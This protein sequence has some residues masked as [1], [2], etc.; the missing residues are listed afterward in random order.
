MS[1]GRW[2]PTMAW[3]LALWLAALAGPGHAD[4]L[5]WQ[6]YSQRIKA[7]Q[8]ITPLGDAPFGER[9][10]LYTGELSF[11][12]AD[13]TLKGR[14]PDLVIGRSFSP[15]IRNSWPSATYG[16]V[17]WQLEIPRIRTRSPPP[18]TGHFWHAGPEGGETAA[19]CSQFSSPPLTVS[20]VPADQWW[21]GQQLTTADGASQELLRRD[22]ANLLAPDADA[23]RYPVVTARHRQIRGLP[24]TANRVAG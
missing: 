6:E 5:A 11:Y 2:R 14:G 23:A 24:Q 7:W 9:M 8:T 1:A 20:P 17:D 3:C 15:K 10:S 22:P 12:Q 18:A 21:N 13:I 16:F 19:R 4:S